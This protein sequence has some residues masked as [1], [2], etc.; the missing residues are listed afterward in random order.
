M[1][2]IITFVAQYCI[3]IPVAGWIFLFFRLGK[4]Q[5]MRFALFSLAAVIATVVMVKIASMLHHDPRPFVRDHVQPYFGH[6]N[7]NGFPSD[8]T[9]YSA[10]IALVVMRYRLWLGSVLLG[11]ALLIGTARVIAGVHHAQDIVG[12]IVCAG[13]GVGI[14]WLAAW[15]VRR[16][17][18]KQ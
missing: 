12:G 4:Q 17:Q 9:A 10:L 2:G 8:H 15:T 14:T 7:D 3:A 11:T 13:L 18:A 16:M 1:H 6:T 5:R